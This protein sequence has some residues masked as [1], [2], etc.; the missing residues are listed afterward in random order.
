MLVAGVRWTVHVGL[1]LA[2]A[3]EQTLLVEA[4]H[5]RHHGRVG[6]LAGP[7]EIFDDVTHRRR[8]TLPKPH[9]DFGLERSEELLLG[10]LRSAKAAKVRPAHGLIIPLAGRARRRAAAAGGS[11]GAFRPDPRGRARARRGARRRDA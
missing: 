11:G 9:H 7:R 10:L 3:L 1:A 2:G 4:D 8:A 6:E 5:D